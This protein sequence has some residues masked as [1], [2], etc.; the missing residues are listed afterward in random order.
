MDPCLYIKESA[1]FRKIHIAL[2][3]D[4][5]L[6]VGHPEALK[7]RIQGPRGEGLVLKVEDDLKDYLS[8]EIDFSKDKKSVWL[9]QPH[10]ISN[11]KK[12]FGD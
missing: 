8:C 7:E 2:Y 6:I 9:G 12:A 5:N 11:L 1:K 10:L 3:V 4:D